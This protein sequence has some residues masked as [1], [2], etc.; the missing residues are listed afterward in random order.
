MKSF[1]NPT[2]GEVI[3]TLNKSDI[4][5]MKACCWKPVKLVKTAFIKGN[6][7]NNYSN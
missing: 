1:I 3:S 2:T 7:G 5:M 4:K 6:N